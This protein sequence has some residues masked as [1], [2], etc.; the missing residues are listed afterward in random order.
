MTYLAKAA[1]IVIE[2][3]LSLASPDLPLRVHFFHG[4]KK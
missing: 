1:I 3:D 4:D 2:I